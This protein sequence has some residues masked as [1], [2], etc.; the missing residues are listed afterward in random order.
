MLCLTPEQERAQAS[1]HE[2]VQARVAPFADAWDREE[3]LPAEA[4]AELAAAGHLGALVPAEFG[5]TGMDAFTLGLLCEAIGGGCAS[6]RSVLTVH[7]MVAH[8]IARWGSGEQRSRWLPRL[9]SGQ[10]V[11]AFALTE[12]GAGSDAAALATTARRECGDFVLDGEKRWTTYGQRAGLFLVF[13]RCEDRLAAFVVERSAPG[14]TVEPVTGLLG[15]RASMVATI[16]LRDCRVPATA[17][18]G[19]VGFGLSTVGASALDVG[20]FTVAWGCVGMIQA[21]LDAST[22]HASRREQFGRRLR[23]QPLVQRLIAGMAA[24][25]TASRLLCWEAARQRQA[26]DPRSVTAACMAKYFASRAAFQSAS[27]AVQVHGAAGCGP[28][29][30]PQRH[31][32]DAKVMEIIEG[33]TQLQETMLAGAAHQGH[34]SWGGTSTG[35][36]GEVEA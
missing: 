4:V 15:T 28:D 20:R 18:L 5:G 26:R 22:G 16:G 10:L 17:L 14:L 1:F 9:A 32:R 8:A 6:L 25:A 33:S 30:P 34:F 21:C 29:S 36:A 27:D 2:L 7:S 3:R 23:D 13:A 24:S 12:S 11:G 35:P 31:L 19:R